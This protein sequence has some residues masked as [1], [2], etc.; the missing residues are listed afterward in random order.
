MANTFSQIYLHFVFS[1]KNREPWIKPTI[2]ERVW[3]YIAGIAKAHGL[4]AIQVGGMEDHIHAL[5][6]SATTHSPSHI[7]KS[8][9]ADSSKWIHNEFTGMAQF[10]WQDGYG[11]FSVSRSEIDRVVQYIRNQREHHAKQKFED[12]YASLLKLHG[13]DFDERFL[14]G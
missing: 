4:T 8:L 6:S 1:T 7:A 12:E 10:A 5:T 3:A 11:V 14:L 13:I 2:E 9:K